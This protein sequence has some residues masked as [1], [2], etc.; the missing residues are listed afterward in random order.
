MNKDVRELLDVLDTYFRVL[1]ESDSV[2]AEKLFLPSCVLTH[3]CHKGTQVMS[4]EAY[5]QVLRE[6]VSPRAQGEV[7]YGEVLSIDFSGNL[8]A[9]AKLRSKVPPRHFEDVLT[10][11]YGVSGWRIAAKVYRIL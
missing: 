10:L 11:V 7:L 9:I 3:A 6:R 4:M 5:L 8:V 1:Y 2:A